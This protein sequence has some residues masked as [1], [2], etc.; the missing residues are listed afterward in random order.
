MA[1]NTVTNSEQTPGQNVVVMG[2][3]YVGL[4]LCREAVRAEHNVTGIDINAERVEAIKNGT[5]PP[6][7]LTTDELTELLGRG[8][9]VTSDTTALHTA[10]VV[11]V[12]VPTPLRAGHPDLTAVENAARTIRDH[13]RPATLVVLE[14]TTYP[15]T[16]QDVVAPILSE[17]G[18][19]I[20]TEV[21][22]AYSPERIQPGNR[23]FR[24]RDTPKIVAGLTPICT[25]LAANFYRT[26][27]DT[28][29]IAAGLRE[30]EMAK[31]LE[32]IYLN[33]N[34]AL[35][36]EMAIVC[37]ELGIDVWEVIRCASTKPHGFQAFSPGPGVGGH[38]IPVD[39][40]Y[41]T[42]LARTH[43]TPA[44]L[45]ETAHEINQRMPHHIVERAYAA[46]GFHG[47]SPDRARITLVGITYKPNA[48]D[49]RET[50]AGPIARM[51]L[52]RGSEVYYSDRHVEDWTVEGTTIPRA[53]P[54]I[55]RYDLGIF[56]QHHDGTDTTYIAAA[57][58]TVLDTRGKLDGPNVVRL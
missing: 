9:A 20:G 14:S 7:S 45:V 35:V 58:S 25:E 1:P 57:C 56:L 26:L 54:A 17:S 55:Q 47:I 11:V 51:L 13:L 22:L 27:V 39:P 16:T 43:R 15:G 12:C 21:A 36:N 18:L 2:V 10:D 40:V 32:N 44:R 3:G 8:F 48:A 49:L 53:D 50:P 38:C 46:L 19:D 4:S 30:A 24:L 37:G 6:D 41:L 5:P 42:T 34:I 52:N 23:D 31:L 29:V 33:V 28:V